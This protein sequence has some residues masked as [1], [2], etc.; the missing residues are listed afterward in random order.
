MFDIFPALCPPLFLDYFIGLAMN[1]GEEISAS[2]DVIAMELVKFTEM[3]NGVELMS[4]IWT[5]KALLE[6]VERYQNN[7]DEVRAVME[8]EVLAVMEAL[9][10]IR[11][12]LKELQETEPR[13]EE[14]LLELRQF[15]ET[16]V[17]KPLLKKSK[18][19]LKRGK[20][21]LKLKLKLQLE[22]TRKVMELERKVRQANIMKEYENDLL[23]KVAEDECI[24]ILKSRMNVA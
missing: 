22:H 3:R 6:T 19:E 8:D 12:S 9:Y 2:L 17:V 15:L 13:V 21:E 24:I 1:L 5:A 10:E 20:R 14:R 18:M 7:H 4:E 23:L 16:T 11:K